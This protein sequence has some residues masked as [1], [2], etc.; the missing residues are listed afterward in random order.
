MRKISTLANEKNI[1]T[2]FKNTEAK[3]LETFNNREVKAI[4][5]IRHICIVLAANFK[6]LLHED[7]LERVIQHK[8]IPDNK[9]FCFV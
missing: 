2:T 5:I 1:A 7:V 4:A 8:Y 3:R 9:N 6:S